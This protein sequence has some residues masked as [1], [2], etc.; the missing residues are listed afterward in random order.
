MDT[1]MMKDLQDHVR[2]P[3]G[4]RWSPKLIRGSQGR[5]SSAKAGKSKAVSRVRMDSRSSKRRTRR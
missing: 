3:A 4:V 5:S 2:V 1:V